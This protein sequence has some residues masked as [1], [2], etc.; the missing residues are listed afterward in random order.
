[1]NEKTSVLKEIV[2]KLIELLDLSPEK[3]QIEKETEGFKVEIFLSQ[4]ESGILVGFHGRTLRSLEFLI[5]L[6]FFKKI[7]GWEHIVVDINNYK[8]ER[9]EYLKRLAEN[10]VKK[11]A[12]SNEEAVLPYLSAKERRFIHMFLA[13]N[14]DVETESRG[15]GRDRRLVIR[16]K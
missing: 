1:M 4:Q 14:S 2:E 13:D 6:M 12:A 7:G 15:Q 8:Q 10:G 9:R 5:N 16:P 3:W 11:T